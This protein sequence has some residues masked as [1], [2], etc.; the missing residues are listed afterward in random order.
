MEFS[1]P[2]EGLELI[3]SALDVHSPISFE[4]SCMDHGQGASLGLVSKEHEKLLQD[5]SFDLW[6]FLFDSYWGLCEREGFYW[7]G[8]GG[9][10]IYKL[11]ESLAMKVE[12]SKGYFCE[13][14]S[15]FEE[16]FFK[17]L[18]ERIRKYI[19]EAN[20]EIPVDEW[21]TELS[22]ELEYSLEEGIIKSTCE[23]FCADFHDS[24]LV[25]DA[26]TS[27]SVAARLSTELTNA[28]NEWADNLPENTTEAHLS[29]KGQKIFIY[30]LP[31]DLELDYGATC[32]YTL[33]PS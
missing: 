3:S 23:V 19:L 24:S 32:Q 11:G 21:N 28:T 13:C 12:F 33:I 31:A 27:K 16:S 29:L 26:E 2:K 4:A 15:E 14:D 30:E 22:V 9:Y 25:M 10:E 20:P 18:P 17:D 1:I 8:D 7:A 6:F 5:S